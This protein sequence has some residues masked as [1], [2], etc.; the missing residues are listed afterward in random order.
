MMHRDALPEIG[1]R[2]EANVRQSRE[3]LAERMLLGQDPSTGP[4]RHALWLTKLA[5]GH[6]TR[7]HHLLAGFVRGMPYKRMEARS[8]LTPDQLAACFAIAV[9]RSTFSC[10]TAH[11]ATGAIAADGEAV[12]WFRQHAL[13][14]RDVRAILDWLKGAPAPSAKPHSELCAKGW[15]MTG[16]AP[17]CPVGEEAS[18]SGAAAPQTTA[19]LEQG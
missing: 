11:T 18:S 12:A 5:L 13:A 7:L 10:Q 4:A 17:G 14:E 6:T 15:I 19:S 3:L 8:R 2:I 16:C 1:L 9:R